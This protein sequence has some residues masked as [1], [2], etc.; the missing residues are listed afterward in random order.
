MEHRTAASSVHRV[1]SS[2]RVGNEDHVG[3]PT[4]TSE[5][6]NLAVESTPG[7][8]KVSQGIRKAGV[9]GNPSDPIIYQRLEESGVRLHLHP[10]TAFLLSEPLLF[11]LCILSVR[12]LIAAGASMVIHWSVL[13]LPLQPPLLR[14]CSHRFSAGP[15]TR[16]AA[17]TYD[18]HND[19]VLPGPPSR[20]C[21]LPRQLPSCLRMSQS[22][23]LGGSAV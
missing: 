14:S 11:L 4:S 5:P 15:G 20:L 9:D 3:S 21:H 22:G 8:S 1:Q 7:F 13:K 23:S 10:S 6:R 12:K 18:G 16:Q 2:L 17:G 19:S